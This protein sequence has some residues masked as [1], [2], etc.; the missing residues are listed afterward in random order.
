MTDEMLFDWNGTEIRFSDWADNEYGV[1]TYQTRDQRYEFEFDLKPVGREV[2]IHIKRQPPYGRR[3]SDGHS[4]HRFG[5]D[6]AQPYI[7]IKSDLA[8]TTVPE[9][10]SWAV[11]WAEQ[12]AQYIDTG[13]SFS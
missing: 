9:A 11:F 6:T 2:R 10:L 1:Y 12:T 7:C 5:V 8:P 13:R 3:R 4:T